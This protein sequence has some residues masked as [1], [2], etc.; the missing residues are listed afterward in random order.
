MKLIPKAKPIRIRIK[1]GGVE[2]SSVES[3]CEHF[4]FPDLLPLV[5][6]GGL[7][8]WLQQINRTDLQEK[9]DKIATSANRST[10][11]FQ[12]G[13]AFFHLFVEDKRKPISTTTILDFARCYPHPSLGSP[14]ASWW[15]AAAERENG[16]AQYMVGKM[17][18]DGG[19]TAEALKWY[20]KA[21]KKENRQA[22]EA[23]K[24]L[25]LKERNK[26]AERI[27]KATNPSAQNGGS[28]L[29]PS[30]VKEFWEALIEEERE[31]FSST[32]ANYI[33]KAIK[34]YVSCGSFAAYNDFLS[35]FDYLY[36]FFNDLE[37]LGKSVSIGKLRRDYSR[38]PV[39]DVTL[40]YIQALIY[41]KNGNNQKAIDILNNILS[42]FPLAAPLHKRLSSGANVRSIAIL[43]EKK[44][45]CNLLLL[46]NERK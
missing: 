27:W 7:S 26:E 41:A 17:Y 43:E 14:E 11:S 45:V 12:Q 8:R 18:Q 1:S 19:K 22:I 4:S 44:R 5:A 36:A 39:Y 23:L 24:S 25:S 15:K 33:V 35:R 21:A 2:H 13:E 38:R 29:A 37:N 30:E 34:Y 28:E 6:S 46:K 16:E 10:L 9:L 40:A 3:L 42:V 31:K 20:E 32:D